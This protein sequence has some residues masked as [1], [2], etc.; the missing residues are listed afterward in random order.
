MAI[1]AGIALAFI[2]GF[3]WAK[4]ADPPKA[5]V[6][7]DGV[8]LTGEIGY[9]AQVVVTLWF[10]VV[11][12]IGGILSGLVVGLLGRRH[13]GASVVA[14]IVMCAVASGLG[15]WA[16]I[17]VFGPDMTA[18]VAD[19]SSGDLITTELSI[20]SDVAYL[21]WPIGGLLGAFVG[22]AF[23]PPDRKGPYAGPMSSTVVGHSS[24]PG[25]N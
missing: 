11:G 16:G 23:W 18:Q 22:I 25:G 7:D 14:V 19:A 8:F 3:V 17:H 2:G 12:L 15:A 13:G 21:G 10:I 4:I 24:T 9:N 5:L 6:T 1:L 20:G